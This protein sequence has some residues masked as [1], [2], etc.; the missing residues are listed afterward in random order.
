MPGIPV[1]CPADNNCLYAGGGFDEQLLKILQDAKSQK[2][3][4]PD[5]HCNN[6]SLPRKIREPQQGSKMAK[7]GKESS[8]NVSATSSE[9]TAST[10]SKPPRDQQH[11]PEK[12]ISNGF[13]VEID[14]FTTVLLLQL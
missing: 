3:K 5:K 12:K 1:F 7:E 9:D 11:E 13:E 4:Q 10:S 14:P 2:T 6:D 8:S